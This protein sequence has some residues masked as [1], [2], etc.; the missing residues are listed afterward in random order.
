VTN[1]Q[2]Q[3]LVLTKRVEDN[4]RRISALERI[5]WE[6]SSLIQALLERA[7]YTVKKSA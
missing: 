1:T 6:Q 4:E 3:V 2:E 5:V 7:N